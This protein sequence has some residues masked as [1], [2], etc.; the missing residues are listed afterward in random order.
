L[1]LRPKFA[2][3]AESGAR[4]IQRYRDTEIQRYRDTEIQRYRDIWRMERG[5]SKRSGWEAREA[6]E[7]EEKR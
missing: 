1:R 4:L 2:W 7:A 6:R 5:R 3:A